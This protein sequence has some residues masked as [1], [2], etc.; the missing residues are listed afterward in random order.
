MRLN[1]LFVALTVL[2]STAWLSG[3]GGPAAPPA[4]A[5]KNSPG[6]APAVPGATPI[7]GGGAADVNAGLTE[8]D[9]ADRKAAEKQETC[10]VSGE[11]LGSMG[12]PY[13]VTV[14][15]RTFFLCCDGCLPELNAHPDKY[16]KKLKD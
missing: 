3:C 12:K 4:G 1:P 5:A 10:P 15:G 6:A 2:V 8:L 16:L 14:K 13:K 7:V 11:K 9:E